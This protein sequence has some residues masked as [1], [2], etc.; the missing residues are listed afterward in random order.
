MKSLRL[1]AF[2]AAGVMLAS[3]ASAQMPGAN[4]TGLNA[5]MLKLFEDFNGFTAKTDIRLQEKGS[6]DAMTMSVDFAMRDGKTR[7]DLDMSAMKSKQMPPETLAAFKV[8]GLDK[9]ATIVRPDRKTTLLIYP[10]VKGYA[11]MPMPKDEAAS[12]DRKFKVTKTRLGN[13]AIDE[14]A[15]E[16][17]KVVV[18]ADNGE[19]HEATVWYATALKSFPIKMQMDQQQMTVVLQY[20]D[21]KL[22][23]PEAARFEAPAGFTRHP[24]V[25]QLMQNAMMRSLGAKN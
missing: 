20:R 17:N 18:S 3:A 23:Q 15:C 25:E 6:S 2:A 24:S 1:I 9:L 4:Q 10:A 14:Q 19:K 22:V 13:E 12:L 21:V 8:A 7:M 11:E 5:A 16:K